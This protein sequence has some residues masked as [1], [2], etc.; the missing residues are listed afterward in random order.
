[1]VRAW[2]TSAIW[3]ACFFASE[4]VSSGNGAASPG[5]WQVEQELKMMGAISR[6]KVTEESVA[7]SDK[8]PASRGQE[9]PR[10]TI[11]SQSDVEV[12]GDFAKSVPVTPVAATRA[13]DHANVRGEEFIPDL[14]CS[15]PLP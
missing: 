3:R 2:V 14:R 15:I 1:M 8:L 12:T 7:D 6:L 4:K 9:C 13:S 11:K 10:H 5:W